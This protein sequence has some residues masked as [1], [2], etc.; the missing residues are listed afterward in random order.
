M[1]TNYITVSTNNVS[2]DYL[3]KALNKDGEPISFGE[4]NALRTKFPSL[5]SATTDL[6]AS[7]FRTFLNLN[8]PALALD[9]NVYPTAGTWTDQSGN[10]YNFIFN[11][12][13]YTSTNGINYIGETGAIKRV[14]G[15]VL[16]DVPTATNR[17]IICF[18][19]IRNSTADYRTLMRGATRDHHVIINSGTNTLGMF[20]NNAA[21][22]ISGG[23][24]ITTLPNPYT[25]FNM[26]T[27]KLSTA[28]PYWQ[29]KYNNTSS[30]NYYNI[31]NANATATEG[32]C[33]IANWPN[34]T[35]TNTY[36]QPWGNI[37][38]FLQYNSHL[39]EDQINEVYNRF[40]PR[41]VYNM[42]PITSGMTG[43]YTGE[44]W[45]GSQWTDVS[46]SGNH[47]TTYAGTINTYRGQLADSGGTFY[48]GIQGFEYLGG[49]TSAGITFPVALTGS[50]YTLIHV[51]RFSG[52]GG[53]QR[54][55]DAS[56]ANW[57]S[58]FWA[59]KSGLAFHEAW[60]T[61]ET[62]DNY[63]N[64]WII[65]VDQPSFYRSNGIQRSFRVGGSTAY[66]ISINSGSSTEKSDWL[67]A[68]TIIFNRLLSLVEILQMEDWLSEKYAINIASNHF[69][70]DEI[71]S[72]ARSNLRGAY[73]L[74]RLSDS[75][76]GPVVRIRRSTDS[77]TSDFYAD[78][79][80]QLGYAP[81]GTGQTLSSWLGAGTGY[82]V[83][84]YDQSGNGRDAT[85]ATTSAQP[86]INTTSRLID[87]Q[88]S[89]A[90]FLN[91]PSGTIPVGTLNAPYT[92]V[93]KHGTINNTTNGGFL[94]SGANANSQSNNLRCA[95]TF[96]WNYWYNN[97]YA[98]GAT[99]K[100]G[101]IIVVSYNGT[102]RQGWS[103]RP[104]TATA[105]SGYT[106][107]AGQQ[108]IGK[109]TVN[110][111]LN[112]QMYYTFIFGA[113]I[114]DADRLI[115]APADTQTGRIVRYPNVSLADG[116]GTGLTGSKTT[117]GLPYAVGTY[118]FAASSQYSTSIE[119]PSYAFDLSDST[120][121]T[122]TGRYSGSTGAYTGS[123]ST[124]VSGTAYTG[125]Y[126]QIK[127]PTACT[128]SYIVINDSGGRNCTS[129]VIAASN[130]GTTW[131]LL[132][133]D[134]AVPTGLGGERY[135]A[136]NPGATFSYYRYIIRTINPANQFGFFSMTSM[137]V[138]GTP[139]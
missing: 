14:V 24:D 91:M 67:C 45:T 73:A 47:C 1:T 83:T 32:I 113:A 49:N 44:S 4:L 133:S 59:G 134:T 15:G 28:S 52:L 88:N 9:T 80:G 55:F 122:T 105:S 84:W 38:L 107:A 115:L 34:S 60:V 20:D 106:N 70:L 35:V 130:D 114:S 54:I 75:Y 82:V 76:T 27:F 79:T 119:L 92:L 69:V 81:N 23:F 2:M 10:G 48:Q 72:T 100:A 116:T 31:T 138:W 128:A 108:Y 65:S 11:S 110:E 42:P 30:Q 3:R 16:T 74:F 43:Y 127:I 90:Q 66:S 77:V 135:I 51:A 25:N 121:W 118:S 97:D 39:T 85:Q 89:S 123:T 63:G 126:I 21:S 56:N 13:Q 131:T 68:T 93:V 87:F 99:P 7:S 36:L 8:S 98:F 112:G 94:G 139:A 57:L 17:T 103:T 61:G 95:G 62:T 18:T 26:L 101:N 5:P 53:R 129:E 111:Y 104:Y 120:F 124:T 40:A 137:A 136:V 12:T 117:I 41:F 78:V 46:G 64:S 50:S 86:I 132:H 19:T 6:A 58:G 29:F 125:E 22:F 102:N 96:Y 37:G 109:T 71:S 33:S